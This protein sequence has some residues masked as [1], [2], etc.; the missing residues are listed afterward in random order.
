MSRESEMLFN[1]ITNIDD[2]IIERAQRA[3]PQNRRFYRRCMGPVAAMLAIAVLA[4]V[5]LRGDLISSAYAVERAEYPKSAPRG[6]NTQEYDGAHS[7]IAESVP[8]FL[9]GAA[10]G[11]CIY[12]PLSAYMAL[13]MTAELTDGRSRAQ[14]LYAL[15]ESDL[16]ALREHANVIWNQNYLDDEVGKSIL[17]SS[18]WMDDSIQY[19]RDAL[20]MLAANYYAS[21]FSGKMGSRGFDRAM[22]SW[23]NGQTHGMLAGKAANE[24]TRNNDAEIDVLTLASTVYFRGKWSAKFDKSVTASG[25]FHAPGS[26]TSCEFMGIKR[27]SGSYFWFEHF[28]AVAQNFTNGRCMWYILPDEGV[29]P[30][31]LLSDPE[32]QT[33]LSSD[34]FEYTENRKEV[35]INLTVPKFDIDAETE[36][37]KGFQTL[38]VTDIFDQ[39]VSSFTPLTRD[40]QLDGTGVW[41][42]EAKQA[43][44]VTID[45]DGCEATTYIKFNFGAGSGMPPTDEI[46]FTLDRPFLFAITNAWRG[47]GLPLFVGMVNQP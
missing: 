27:M 26:D 29:T 35:Y 33:F 9:S 7:F 31:E 11:N 47:S 20:Q 19:E 39:T 38:G 14:I 12:S 15:G 6:L 3:R 37:S 23:L 46:D 44:R 13:A 22:Q 41:L 42:A 45:E 5:L 24:S 16:E 4:N 36:L 10:N 30:E 1:G 28:G 43:A 34:K 40:R 17:A 8:V 18:V 21:S 25:T 32:L 2:A